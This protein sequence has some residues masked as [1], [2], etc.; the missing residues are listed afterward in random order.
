[1]K[2][3]F[4]K[5]MRVAL[6]KTPILG[7][8]KTSAVILAGGTGSRVGANTPKQFLLLDGIPVL[9]H[10]LKAF[11]QC[12]SIWEIVL[13]TRKEDV[14]YCRSLV[15]QY[16]ITKCTAVVVG[17]KERN[18]SAAR[19]CDAVNPKAVYVAIHDGARCL[20]TPKQITDVARAAY[21]Y[22]AATAAT[23]VT[24]TIKIVNSYGFIESNV[25]RETAWAAATPQIFHRVY[26]RMAQE[27]AKK[28]TQT[29]TDDNMLMELIGQRVM[30][31]DTGNENFKITVPSDI[32]RAEAVLQGRKRKRQ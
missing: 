24:D 9:V 4:F 19:G 26:Y 17:G 3:H 18:E 16:G 2:Y 1:M 14:A 20:V 10:T 30:V 23:P 6:H 31:V 29:I 5:K 22:K 25:K 11:Q 27:Q 15:K 28:E 32:Q 21:A 8:P 7:T 13:V 12:K